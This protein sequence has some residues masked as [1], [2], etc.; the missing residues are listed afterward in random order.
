MNKSR[1]IRLDENVYKQLAKLRKE[2]MKASGVNV[3]FNEVIADLLTFFEGM[4][5]EAVS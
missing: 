5:D 2:D 1:N 4:E 3:T